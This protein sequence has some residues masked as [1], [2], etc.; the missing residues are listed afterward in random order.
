M[1]SQNFIKLVF[2]RKF[3]GLKYEY[4]WPYLSA[5]PRLMNHDTGIRKRVTFAFGTGC[6]QYAPILAA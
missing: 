6:Q 4:R 2:I 1:V 5:A 3:P